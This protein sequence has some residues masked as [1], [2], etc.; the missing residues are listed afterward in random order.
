MSKDFVTSP[1]CAEPSCTEPCLGDF[2]RTPACV[3]QSFGLAYPFLS[4]AG[5]VACHGMGDL[6]EDHLF[7]LVIGEIGHK[8]G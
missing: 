3:P 6:V 8:V 7:H 4:M 5:T 1:A 2:D